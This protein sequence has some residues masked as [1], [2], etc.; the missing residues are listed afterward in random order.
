MND[1]EEAASVPT[2]TATTEPSAPTTPN[3]PTGTSAIDFAELESQL[4]HGALT[5]DPSV[6]ESYSKDYSLYSPVGTAAA[7]VRA[8]S[9]EDVQATMRFA[10]A[11]DIPVVPQGA[12]T[13][14]SGGANAIDGC[15]L[16][17]VAKM[18]KI[19]DINA[20]DT[21][22]TVQ[23]GIINQELKDALRPHGL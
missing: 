13:G 9:V 16:L 1:K 5:T 7:L 14:I 23:P 20:T 3:A 4:S 18:N 19:L 11:R 17:S 21:C 2:P 22:V 8:H 10:Y 6:I 12:R 15:I